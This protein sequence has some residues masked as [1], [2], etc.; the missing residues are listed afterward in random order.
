MTRWL[1][2]SSGK[3]WGRYY[4]SVN[5]ASDVAL[6]RMLLEIDLCTP[7]RRGESSCLGLV[8]AYF[9]KVTK[10][11]RLEIHYG[12]SALLGV[13]WDDLRESL[14]AGQLNLVQQ[15]MPVLSSCVA[16]G[17]KA[18]RFYWDGEVVGTM[19][20][21]RFVALLDDFFA[22]QSDRIEESQAPEGTDEWSGNP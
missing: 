12:E 22:N 9:D 20:T 15:G 4:L 17:L 8:S 10:L 13:H 18:V 21:D 16:Q 6:D 11:D 2:W 14:V 1:G 7:T 19:W 3:G 5:L